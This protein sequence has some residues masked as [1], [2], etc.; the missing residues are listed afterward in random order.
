MI[1]VG[2]VGA[3]GYVGG[4]A[5]RWILAHPGLELAAVT[6]RTAA[7]TPLSEA[8]P[9]LLGLTDRVLEPFDPVRLARLDAVLL[10]TPH[11]T[12]AS[13]AAALDDAGAPVVVDCAA[14]HRHAPGWIY[15]AP[16]WHREALRGARRIA[17]PGCF[18]TAIALALAPF[19]RWLDGPVDVVAA[20]GSTGS[21]AAP[22]ATTHHPERFVDLKAYKV[23]RHQ[24]VPEIRTFL[25]GIGAPPGLSLHFVP[26]SAPVDRGILATCLF[27]RPDGV[28][29]EQVLAEACAHHPLLHHRGESPRL[30]LVRGTAFC[31]LHVRTD[32]ARVAVLSAID[33]LGRGAAAQ[34]IQALEVA[35]EV[36]G[37]SPLGAPPLIP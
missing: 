26:L 30:R 31:D 21:G 32:G 20:T 2:V 22:S 18:A 27:A 9:G 4:E 36:S 3:T 16:E 33:N 8:L 25:E 5:V 35:L 11:G 23:L 19:A 6:S 14:D 34:A 28:D 37:P 15:G 7:G 29:P 10:C 13:L 24:H 17:A 1:R 12:S